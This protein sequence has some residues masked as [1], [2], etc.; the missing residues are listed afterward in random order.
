M[1]ESEEKQKADEKNEGVSVGVL[2]QR[3]MN[4]NNAAAVPVQSAPKPVRGW[5]GVL[6]KAGAAFW[7]R[8]TE[9]DVVSIVQGWFPAARAVY[10]TRIVQAEEFLVHVVFPSEQAL[11]DARKVE[12]KAGFLSRCVGMHNCAHKEEQVAELVVLELF[13]SSPKSR[14]PCESAQQRLAIQR[15]LVKAVQ[16]LP[17]KPNVEKAWIKVKHGSNASLFAYLVMKGDSDVGKV[18]AEEKKLHGTLGSAKTVVDV[19]NSKAFQCCR[20][21]K[22]RGHNDSLCT[23]VYGGPFAIKA[24]FAEPLSELGR[25]QIV[26]SHTAWGPVNAIFTGSKIGVKQPRCV[27]YLTYD[28]QDQLLA[29]GKL[30][31]AQYKAHLLYICAMDGPARKSACEECGDHHAVHRCS[32]KREVEREKALPAR[33]CDVV[34]AVSQPASRPAAAAPRAQAAQSAATAVQ[35]SQSQVMGQCFQWAESGGN[36]SF[37][38]ACK[39]IHRK[40]TAEERRRGR[41]NRERPLEPIHIQR[42]SLAPV[43]AVL[44]RESKELP[45]APLSPIQHPPRQSRPASPVTESQRSVGGSSGSPKS[46]PPRPVASDSVPKPGD[47]DDTSALNQGPS[48]GAGSGSGSGRDF[49]DAR[50]GQEHEVLAKADEKRRDKKQ[51]ALAEARS[52][53]LSSAAAAVSAAP[54]GA[55]SPASSPAATGSHRSSSGAQPVAQVQDQQPTAPAVDHKAELVP[56]SESPKLQS[57]QPPTATSTKI[58]PTAAVADSTARSGATY[59]SLGAAESKD[60]VLSSKSDGSSTQDFD[61]HG[62][63]DS[64][65]SPTS[66]SPPSTPTKTDLGQSGPTPSVSKR[67][68]EQVRLQAIT[69]S[70]SAGGIGAS[71]GV[72]KA[73]SKTRIHDR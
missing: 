26:E 72:K 60:P 43:V 21:C 50:A 73:G 14:P 17:G 66:P 59:P 15:S 32:F 25:Q 19:P 47:A 67:H 16:E 8:K 51:A 44:R 23:K 5:C 36:C 57:T 62:Y 20:E 68:K 56:Q 27:T 48:A 24:V 46:S 6:D 52:Q 35:S 70:K 54:S 18:V 11:L 69:R 9:A 65:P 41:M 10:E 64:P 45:A 34:G 38:S 1:L 37:G 30:F 22:G 13:Y 49:V 53:E 61:V 33:Y 40:P 58:S 7:D 63:R 71:S 28:T 2:F 4:E 42:G 12:Q 29:A 31:H 39:Y 3:V 55:R